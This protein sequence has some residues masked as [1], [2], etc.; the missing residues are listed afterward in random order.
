[1][2]VY[3]PTRYDERVDHLALG[4]ELRDATSDQRLDSGVDVRIERFGAPIDQWR[5]WRPGQSLTSYLPSMTRH[6]SGRFAEVYR[7]G[8]PTDVRLRVVDERS[9]PSGQRRA[10]GRR[11]V[12]RRV[13][14]TIA[15]EQTVTD[16]DAAGSPHPG[17]RRAFPLWC[18]PGAAAPIARGSTVLRGQLVRLDTT[19]TPPVLVP[20]RWARIRARNDNGGTVGWAH[21]DDR[22]EFV[23]VV[24]NTVDD[25]VVPADPL[26]VT[27]TIAAVLPPTIPNPLDP[28]LAEIDPLWDLPVEAISLSPSP[29][30]EP[31][32]NG[33][34]FLPGQAQ[35]TPLVPPPPIGLPLGRE[36][37][38][39]IRIS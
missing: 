19:A 37:S 18:F 2:N 16:G 27:L 26:R 3:T 35:F 1:M 30:I 14:V 4:V 23:L 21:G 31:S 36:T 25:I 20:V 33:R 5:A 38:T 34:R 10:E 32:L 8:F 9:G 22:G 17:W 15:T 24:A 12:P 29:A 6:R 28:S 13:E 7:R 11:I 39:V